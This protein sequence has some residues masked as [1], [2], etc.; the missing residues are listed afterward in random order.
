MSSI[1]L[2]NVRVFD[3]LRN[4]LNGELGLVLSVSA[5]RLDMRDKTG[6]VTRYKFG[7][8]FSRVE[9]DEAVAF[10]AQA[11]LAKKELEK[12]SGVK[13]KRSRTLTAFLNKLAKKR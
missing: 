11:H 3:V 8:H 6:A 2:S 7:K 9:H 12:N 10:R 13:K 4:G 1:E 5:G